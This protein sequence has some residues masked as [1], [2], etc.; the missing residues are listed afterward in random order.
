LHLN[1]FEQPDEGR[2]FQQPFR[3]LFY[4]KIMDKTQKTIGGMFDRI[5]PVYD[6]LNRV[7]SLSLDVLW[8]KK[9]VECLAIQDHERILD[10]ATGTGDLAMGALRKNP[11]CR[12]IGLDISREM[13]RVAMGKRDERDWRDRYSLVAGNAL[14]MPFKDQT[15]HAA[16]VAF[17][18]RNV[19]DVEG[20]F[21]ETIRVL[22]VGGKFVILEL[23]VPPGSIIK[24]V[25]LFYLRKLLPRIG[26]LLSGRSVAYRY[27][28]DSVLVF[29]TPRQV[30]DLLRA[31]GFAVVRSLPLTFGICHLFLAEKR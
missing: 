12:V 11:A 22:K 7:L 6:L 31:A 30:E 13:M 15:V 27:L 2:I 8:R 25:Y 14:R 16:M 1:V 23:S 9:A 5:A 28:R 4:K 17:G 10:I 21:R 19:P 26:S 24:G 18:V 29:H 3:D 20:L